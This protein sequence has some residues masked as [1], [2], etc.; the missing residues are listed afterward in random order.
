MK[1]IFYFVLLTT[2][3]IGLVGCNNKDDKKND[4]ANEGNTEQTE[5]KGEKENS[6]QPLPDLAEQKT[7]EMMLEGMPEDKIVKLYHHKELGFSTYVPD[8][9]IVESNPEIFNVF[10]NFGGTE[11]KDATLKITGQTEEEVIKNLQDNGFTLG[12]VEVKAFD[13]TDKEFSLNKEGMIGHVAFFKHSNDDYAIYYYFP[14]DYAEGFGPRS[15]IIIKEIEW[16]DEQS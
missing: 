14:E 4:K 3:I 1:K 10:A 16:H 13:F 8:D 7:V 11:N 12:K 15:D 2:L 5:N 6:E 9:M